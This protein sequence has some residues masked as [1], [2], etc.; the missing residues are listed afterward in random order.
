MRSCG[1]NA[2]L[3]GGALWLPVEAF[4]HGWASP[5]GCNRLRCT[6][7]GEAVTSAVVA[8]GEVAGGGDA[9]GVVR[10][11]RCGCAQRDES[12]RSSV[13]G[14]PDGLAPPPTSWECAGHP[15]LELPCVL[16]G[17][18]LAEDAGEAEW[19]EIARR[20]LLTPPLVP[21]GVPLGAVWVTRLYRLLGSGE[22]KRKLGEAVA[23]LV[24]DVG[25]GPEVR[26]AALEVFF[27][28][29]AA[30]GAERLAQ[31]ATTQ[32]AALA[33]MA[34]PTRR[35]TSLLDALAQVLHERL[36]IVDGAGRPL[37]GAA[38]AAA[39][40]LALDGI[41][42]SST[43]YTFADYAPAWLWQHAAALVKVRPRWL[44]YLVQ[45]VPAA[46]AALRGPALRE[47]AALGAA[48]A[49]ALRDELAQVASGE[50]LEGLL[51]ELEGRAP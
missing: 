2:E 6:R 37:D 19:R 5:V 18:Q 38:L 49:A 46:P 44:G 35:K 25:E 9:V 43:P 3:V 21:P 47:I 29:P 39:Q 34:H 17:V 16:D 26:A 31:L 42:P 28:D 10:R 51:A 15:E 36:L 14:D 32:R 33:G 11:Y 23:E 45:G 24:E 7:C 12:W 41:G 8:G 4:E 30:P 40:L 27:N 1:P 48:Q 22:A 50:V 20:G 13:A